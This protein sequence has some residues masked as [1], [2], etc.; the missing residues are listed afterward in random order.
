ML[1]TAK[2][3]RFLKQME[4]RRNDFGVCTDA[5]CDSITFS[6]LVRNKGIFSG[7]E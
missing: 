4:S 1:G 6:F 5:P 3:K 7:R 2:L